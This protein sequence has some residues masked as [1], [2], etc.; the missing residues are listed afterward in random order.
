MDNKMLTL[1]QQ[2][3]PTVAAASTELI[4]L[5]AILELP[6]GTEYFISDI[7]GEYDAFNHYLKNASGIILEKVKQVFP[8]YSTQEQNRL[9]FFV[10]Y[11]TDMLSKYDNVLNEA[12]TTA[13]QRQMLFDM[14]ALA[15]LF[16]SKY[17]KSKVRKYM[18][19]SFMYVMQELLYESQAEADKDHYYQAVMNAVFTTQQQNN[20][21]MEMSR[22]IRNL[23]ID[24]LHVVG[25]IFDRGPYPHLVMDKLMRLKNVDVQW[26]N[27]DIIWMGAAS[28]CRVSLANVIRIAARY[29][30]LDCLEDGYGIN[31][32]PLAMFA[33]FTYQDDPCAAF[34]PTTNVDEKVYSERELVAKIHKAISIIQFKVEAAVIQRHPEFELDHR[35]LLDAIDYQTNIITI[36][37][38]EYDLTDSHF[39]TIDPYNPYQLSL[40]E[41]RVL[42]H[43]EQNVMSN[44]LLQQHIRW[45]FDKG[46]MVLPFNQSLL[47]HA[48]VPLTPNGD[49]LSVT[50][51]GQ[52][53]SGAK[54][55]KFL[56]TKIRI[57][58][59]NRHKKDVGERD[60]FVYLWQGHASPLFAK[61]RMTTFERYFI[62]DKKTHTEIMNPYFTLRESPA[63]VEKIL[64]E[65]GMPKTSKIINGHVPLD[66]T[67]GEP[68]VVSNNQVIL[69]DGGMSKQFAAR[70]S[71]G[72]YTLIA[73][74]FAYFLVSHERFSSHM[75][76]IETEEDIISVTRH[77][78][79]STRRQYVYDTDIGKKLR[80]TIADLQSLIRAYREGM[81][82][83]E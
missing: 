69:I 67:Q 82:R 41:E 22:L 61:H 42:H 74:S 10:Y 28:G 14:V 20:L 30:N 25:D 26:G 9:A 15:K 48:A 51:E 77:E 56:E 18:P 64:Q 65:F 70:T 49:L 21:I 60:Y 16:A 29:N 46:S 17:T 31:L 52:N 38:Q 37:G 76:L 3:Y 66:V 78:E 33:A 12:Q 44:E 5:S 8:Q 35:L 81:L 23:A 79:L 36:H 39:P 75:S 63:I 27:H 59:Q 68:A 32:R 40:E 53:L 19:D 24:H 34:M 73:D 54:L 50:L 62:A 7:H 83:E 55:F 4:N 2:Q 43:L 11:P 58:Y 71:I 13:L 1:L 6:K 72:G 80:E 57:A 47:F 45:M